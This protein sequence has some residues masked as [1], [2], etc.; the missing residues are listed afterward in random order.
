MKKLILLLILVTGIQGISTAQDK[1]EK[2]IL[3][4]GE[5]IFSFADVNGGYDNILRFSP[6]FNTQS[7]HVYDYGD[8]AFFYGLGIRNVGFII[9]DNTNNIRYKF[10][11]Y[12]IGVPL[13]A[14]L[15]FSDNMGIYAGYELELPINFKQKTFV[16]ER[17]E[18]KFNSWFSDRTP[19]LAHAMFVGFQFRG[20]LNVKFKYY[21][22]NFFNKDFRAVEDG[23]EIFPYEDMDVHVFYFAL[24]FNIFKN[25]TIIIDEVWTE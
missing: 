7:W 23:I 1:P 15:E 19:T 24:T 11:T 22:N 16:N 13:G 12:N 25:R 20:G 17:K 4:G 5:L 6:V 18:E 14:I 21:L 8:F 10:R 3:S 2:Y 9:D